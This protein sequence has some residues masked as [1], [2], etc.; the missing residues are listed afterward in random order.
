MPHALLLLALMALASALAGCGSAA[1]SLPPPQPPKVTVATPLSRE[2]RDVDE[3]TGRIEAPETVEVRARVSGYLQEIYFQEG[4]IVKK[5]QDLFLIDPRTYSATFDQAKARIKL[6]ESKY[7]FAKSS[8]ARSERLLKSGAGT[9]ET[10]ESDVA[11]EG[12]SLA[13]IESAKADA[14]VARLNVEFTKIQAEI[15]GRIDRA[16]VTRG[17]LIQSGA[18]A[19]ALTRI[20][21][22]DPMY[23]YFNPDELAFLRYTQRRI[24]SDGQMEAQPVRERNIETTIVLADGS[25]YP[26]KGKVDFA[27]NIVDPSTG[28]I[29]V[30]AVFPNPHRALTPGLFVRLRIASEQGYPALLVPERALNTDQSDKFVYIVDDKGLAQRKNVVLGTKH[31]RLRVVKEGL[32]VADKVII[33]G[34]LLVRPEEKVQPTDG[35]IEDTTNDAIPAER[36]APPSDDAPRPPAAKSKAPSTPA[37]P[38]S[39][40]G[41]S[42]P[43]ASPEPSPPSSSDAPKSTTESNA[44]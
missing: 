18:G 10:Y 41:P 11:T 4:D 39:P 15:G 26:E 22:V 17:N 36:S 31:G 33:S 14:E 16:F 2:V 34:G 3:Y 29:Q 13:A 25:V 7:E 35:T 12:E 9:Q 32:A 5:G 42:A 23:V 21:S 44:R 38:A 27:S 28:T 6:Y 19:P 40:P 8:R 43:P 20:V 30:R 37:A 1:G 24:A